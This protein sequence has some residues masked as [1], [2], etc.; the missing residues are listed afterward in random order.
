MGGAIAIDLAT[1]VKCYRLITDGTFSSLRD[2]GKKS[3]PY[4]PIYLMAP[5]KYNNMKKISH[6][7]AP[8]LFIHGTEDEVVPFS[9]G[10]KL[11]NEAVEPKEFYVINGGGH[12]DTYLG[13]GDQY[14]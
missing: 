7:N 2:M 13:E 6:V 3:F 9:Y 11:Y 1:K 4:T 14:F 10:K 12:N 5:D 8:A